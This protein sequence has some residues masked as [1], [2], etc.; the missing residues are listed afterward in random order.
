MLNRDLINYIGK[1]SSTK[2]NFGWALILCSPIKNH[3][4]LV[5]M[6]LTD[7]PDMSILMKKYIFLG[8]RLIPEGFMNLVISILQK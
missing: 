1:P 3:S 2:F 8:M 7:Y 6:Y 4:V 5:T